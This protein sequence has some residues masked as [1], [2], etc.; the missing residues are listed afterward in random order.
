MS[1]EYPRVIA[2][3]FDG[4]IVENEFPEIG[5]ENEIVINDMLKERETARKEKDFEKADKLRDEIKEKGYKIIDT[6]E[7]PKLRKT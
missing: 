5:E 1:N 6:S 2:Y 7:G 4:Y 3:D